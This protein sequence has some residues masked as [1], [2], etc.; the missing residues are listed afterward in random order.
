MSILSYPPYTPTYYTTTCLQQPSRPNSPPKKVKFSQSPPTIA[1]TWN[2]NQYDRKPESI[3]TTI[4]LGLLLPQ[5]TTVDFKCTRSKKTKTNSTNRSQTT[6]CSF[7]SQSTWG[8]TF[9]ETDC[10]AGF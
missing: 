1:T 2:K 4:Q 8:V 6:D 5:T 3:P 7:V 9:D 10:L